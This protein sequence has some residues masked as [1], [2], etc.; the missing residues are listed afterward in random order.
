MIVD[1]DMRNLY[2]LASLL[3]SLGAE[4]IAAADGRKALDALEQDS[5][6]DLVLMDI[7][8]PVM[9]GYEAIREIRKREEWRDLPV[10]ALTANAMK[11]DRDACLA[12]GANAYL[13]KPVDLDQLTVTATAWLRRQPVS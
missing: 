9:D 6:I 8:M 7:M 1:D 3:E 11:E 10:I 13:S 5:R 2:S 4:S 12:A